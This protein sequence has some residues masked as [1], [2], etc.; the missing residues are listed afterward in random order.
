MSVIQKLWDAEENK[1]IDQWNEVLSDDFLI[2]ED[3]ISNNALISLHGI[4][5]PGITA[6]FAIANRCLKYIKNN[7]C[8]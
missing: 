6:S 5:S 2:Y 8:F 1:D 3:I 7:M 4:E